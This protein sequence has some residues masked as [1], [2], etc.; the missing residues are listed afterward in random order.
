MIGLAGTTGQSSGEHLHFEI[1]INGEKVPT[2]SYFGVE[3]KAQVVP[4][5]G[6][7]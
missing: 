4:Y 2:L 3:E 7:K 5:E 6:K 1:R